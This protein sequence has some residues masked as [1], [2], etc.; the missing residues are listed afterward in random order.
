MS[1]DDLASI[2]DQGMHA[3]HSPPYPSRDGVFPEHPASDFAV[4][5]TASGQAEAAPV[6]T[7]T[8][9]GFGRNQSKSP[10]P[11]DTALDGFQ[12]S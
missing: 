9:T 10:R 2:P 6:V 3:S 8:H 11:K 4:A 7:P 5:D 12:S 1:S